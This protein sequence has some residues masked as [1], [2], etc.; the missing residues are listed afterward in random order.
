MVI[1]VN[2]LEPDD[3]NRATADLPVRRATPRFNRF[4]ICEAWYIFASDYHSGQGSYLFGKLYQLHKMGF[5][6][7]PFVREHQTREL[8]P[9][10]RDILANLIRRFRR[11]EF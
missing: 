7:A 4:D 8:D 2:A 9:N 11:G 5:R 10:A 3:R 1:S 6:P